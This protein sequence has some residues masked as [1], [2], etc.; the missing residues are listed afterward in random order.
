MKR[1]MAV[2][3]MLLVAGCS[4]SSSGNGTT[5]PGDDAATD[6]SMQGDDSSSNAD[7]Q[8]QPE[9]GKPDAPSDATQGPDSSDAG[10]HDSAP[11]SPDTGTDGGTDGGDAASCPS[12]W[13][14]APTVSALAL[15]DGGTVIF[16]AAAAGT[17]NYTCTG[18]F[19]DAGTDGGD[20]GE[21]FTWTFVGPQANLND[22]NATLVGHHFAS[23]AG[24]AA[25]EWMTIDSAYVIGH[26]LAA[27]T[28]DGG[29]GSVPWL[30]LQATS[31]GGSG[32]LAQTTFV[33]R[34]DTDGGVAPASGC[35][36]STLGT[37]QQVPYTADYYFFGP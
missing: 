15:P 14:V 8:G 35:D 36:T 20:A 18:T 16:H 17:Q 25:P 31:T 27:Y 37:M 13:L 4:S 12:S 33:Q 9:T 11:D 1:Q 29:S 32:T 2:C 23:E 10:Q 5:N 22:C 21:T 26:K 6:G 7:V 34:L 28:P 19:I 30:L 24:A 3:S